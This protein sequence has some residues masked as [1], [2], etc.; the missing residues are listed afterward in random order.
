MKEKTFQEKVHEVVRGIKKGTVMSYKSVAEK[1]GN[2]KAARAVGTI[3]RKNS[4][5]A[6][7][8]HRVIHSNREVG[9]YNGLLL[10]ENETKADI[11]KKEG[12]RIREGKVEI[13]SMVNII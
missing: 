2:K 12:V 5:M 9:N 11:L 13:I 10:K 1:A 4:D 8:C 6:V 3:V 7:P